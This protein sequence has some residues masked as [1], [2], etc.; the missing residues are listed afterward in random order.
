MLQNFGKEECNI[1]K[2]THFQSWL[3]TV[4]R[5]SDS[6]KAFL[7]YLKVQILRILS[8]TANHGGTSGWPSIW[9]GSTDAQ[10]RALDQ[11]LLSISYIYLYRERFCGDLFCT[12]HAKNLIQVMLKYTKTQ[13]RMTRVGV[14]PKLLITHGKHCF[15]Y[16]HVNWKN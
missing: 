2:T 11:P 12:G 15:P 3:N 13:I 1:T 7:E 4:R 14:Y 16:T 8:L 6:A 5:T 10:I 9:H